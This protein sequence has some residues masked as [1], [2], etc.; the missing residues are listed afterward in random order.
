MLSCPVLVTYSTTWRATL[1][2]VTQLKVWGSLTSMIRIE[3][4]MVPPLGII[5]ARAA[6]ATPRPVTLPTKA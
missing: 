2:S 6:G 5:C 4:R 1:L 3:M